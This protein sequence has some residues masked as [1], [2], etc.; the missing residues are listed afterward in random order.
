VW[1]FNRTRR[2]TRQVAESGPDGNRAYAKRSKT[3][4]KAHNEW[5]AVPVVD[6][7]VPR[8]MVDGRGKPYSTTVA[9]PAASTASGSLPAASCAVVAAV[10]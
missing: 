10:G 7:G 9:L 4:V 6:P 8:E 1:W 2:K 5:T 3:T